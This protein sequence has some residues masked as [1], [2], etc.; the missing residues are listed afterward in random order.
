MDLVEQSKLIRKAKEALD[1]REPYWATVDEKTGCVLFNLRSG[2]ETY[3]FP[4]EQPEPCEVYKEPDF[5][6][7]PGIGPVTAK[8]IHAKGIHSIDVLRETWNI[9]TKDEMKGYIGAK[10][11]YAITQFFEEET[12]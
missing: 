9:W 11:I 3:C 5:T 1:I 12:E 4:P 2:I 7:I 10:A 8:K 6:I